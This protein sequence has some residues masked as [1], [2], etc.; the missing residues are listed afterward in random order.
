MNTSKFGPIVLLLAGCGEFD[1]HLPQVDIHGTVVL[2][3]AAAT[4]T[5]TDP[6]TGEQVETT[7]TR[8]IGPIYMGAFASINEDDFPYPHPEIGPVIGGDRDGNTYPYGGGTIGR[9]D[10]ACFEDLACRVT[11]GRFSN[12]ED[13]IDLF[14]NVLDDPVIDAYGNVVD[15]PEYFRSYCYELFEYTADYELAFISE[16]DRDQDG[17]ISTEEMTLDFTENAEGDFEAEF[18]LWQVTYYPEMKIWGWMDA[19][20]EQFSF[21]TCDPKLGQRNTEYANDYYYGSSYRDLLNYPS[22]Y[23]FEND[24]V[25]SANA[26]GAD[27]VGSFPDADALRNAFAE[28]TEIHVEIDYKVQ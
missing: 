7:D 16:T 20:S 3:R 28:G 21:S 19:P 15:S 11:T 4:R 13:V 6:T 8:F 5:V 24:W 14:N 9:F 26:D 23:I 17:Q 2:P 18:D 10:F 1:E 25:V 22:K 27:L 12:F